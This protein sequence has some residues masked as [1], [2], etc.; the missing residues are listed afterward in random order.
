VE[1]HGGAGDDVLVGGRGAD[2][3]D[4]GDGADILFGGTLESDAGDLLIGGAGDDL[5]VG[6]Y[7]PDTIHGGAGDDLIV[8]GRLFF[9]NLPSSVF[10]LQSEWVS[11]R[12]Y[13]ERVANLLGTGSGPRS[14]GEVFLVAGSSAV[15]DGV[16]DEIFGEANQDWILY[17]SSQD[18]ATDLQVGVETGTDLG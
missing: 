10:A 3:I 16:V 12:P 2:W 5:I 1:F 17:D 14:N 8:T 6:H 7:G 18:L 15:D 9:L 11:N 13:T 4:G